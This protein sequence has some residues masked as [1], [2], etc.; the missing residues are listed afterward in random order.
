MSI[1]NFRNMSWKYNVCVHVT[2]TPF[3]FWGAWVIH[4][5]KYQLSSQKTAKL[6]SSSIEQGFDNYEHLM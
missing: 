3:E 5:L 4:K 6:F 1:R 2:N